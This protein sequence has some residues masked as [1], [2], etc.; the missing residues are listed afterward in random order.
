MDKAFEETLCRNFFDKRVRDRLAYELGTTKKRGEVL[1]KL[2]H[3][4]E[5]YIRQTALQTRFEAPPEQPQ[6]KAFLKSPD[7]YVISFSEIS[8]S[9][10]ELPSAL[11]VLYQNG[12]AYMLISTDL[13]RA[14]LETENEFVRHRAYFLKQQ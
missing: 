11:D 7:C 4:A 2:S 1:K 9:F 10:S 8:G 3:T 12:M 14:Y 5:D 13:E 6:I